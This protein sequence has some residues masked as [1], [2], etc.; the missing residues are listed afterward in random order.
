MPES[1][2]PVLARFCRPLPDQGQQCLLCP[3]QCKLRPG[4]RGFCFVRENQAGQLVSTTYGKS[5]GF[6][7]DPVEK[8]PLNHF[9]PG[10]SVFSFGTAGCNMG[11]KFCQNWHISKAKLTECYCENAPCQAIALA[12]EKSGCQSVAF[13]YNDPI[14]WAEYAIDTAQACHQ[15]GLKTIA[16][17]AG[18]ISSPAR[19]EFFAHMDAANIDLKAFSDKFYKEQC[20]ASLQ[21]VLDTLIY[22]KHHTK[23]W[24]EITTLLIPGLND[25]PPEIQAMCEFI[26]NKLGPEVP[27]HF[28]AFHPD[29]LLDDIPATPLETL[30]RARQQAR[31]CGLHYVYTGNVAHNDTQSTY[32][33]NCG[34]LLIER[35]WHTLGQWNL[36]KSRCNKCQ[37]PISGHFND[38]PDVFSKRMRMRVGCQINNHN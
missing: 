15:R 18:Y 4:Q 24:L 8:K 27:L 22:V 31:E 12:A 16:V 34:Q 11:C 9:Y 36:D 32:C 25:S 37:H 28:T 10:S 20:Q 3:R 14:I 30:L 38:Q 29:F 26:A 23:T 35:N 6:C 33:P 17:T 19:E 13:T 21:P 7:I 2:Q 5:T 1:S